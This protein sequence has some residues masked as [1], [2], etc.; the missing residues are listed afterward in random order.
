MYTPVHYAEF[1]FNAYNGDVER[2]LKH[3]NE[4]EVTERNGQDYVEETRELVLNKGKVGDVKDSVGSAYT[5]DFLSAVGKA[6][7]YVTPKNKKRGN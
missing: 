4:P 7:D 5:A 3:L 6:E 2:I 1:L